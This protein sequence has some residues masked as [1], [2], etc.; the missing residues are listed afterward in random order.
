METVIFVIIFGLLAGIISML[1][2][3]HSNIEY[4]LWVRHLLISAVA[5]YFVFYQFGYNPLMI[6][7]MSYFAD[8]VIERIIKVYE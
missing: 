4:K 8:S 6:F 2:S 5:A 7:G 1:E 3:E